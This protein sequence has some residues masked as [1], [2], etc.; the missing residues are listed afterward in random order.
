M[1]DFQHEDPENWKWGVFYFN[2]KDFRFI[3]P[4]RNPI[5]GWTFNFAHPIAFI[6][7]LL[8]LGMIVFQSIFNK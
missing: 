1:K 3:V 2:K 7:L 8:I 6:I 5:M 4:K